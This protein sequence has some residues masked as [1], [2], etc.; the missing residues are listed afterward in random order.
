M[1][2]TKNNYKRLKK[3]PIEY[4]D[5]VKFELGHTTLR[6]SARQRYMNGDNCY[7]SRIFDLINVDKMRFCKDAY[8]YPPKDC[9]WPECE[10]DDYEALSRAV[11]AIFEVLKK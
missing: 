4:G 6:Y 2:I 5:Q 3:H 8:G 1:K 7:N 10:T 11:I 9:C